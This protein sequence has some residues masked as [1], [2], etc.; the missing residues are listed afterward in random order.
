MVLQCGFVAT[1]FY[2]LFFWFVVL[3]SHFL[4]FHI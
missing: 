4:L 3:S 2:V 1:Y